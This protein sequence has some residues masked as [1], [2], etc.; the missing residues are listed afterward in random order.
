M[1]GGIQKRIEDA[2]AALDQGQIKKALYMT[3]KRGLERHHQWVEQAAR[4]CLANKGNEKAC[5]SALKGAREKLLAT[6]TAPLDD[7]SLEGLEE[8]LSPA[9]PV[10]EQKR[11]DEQLY[12][13]CEECHIAAAVTAFE[14]ICEE[15]SECNCEPV[16]RLL[17]EDNPDTEPAEWIQAMAETLE[18]AEGEAKEKATAALGGL[19][20]YLDKR[21]SPYLKELE[22]RARK[23][24]EEVEVLDK[25]EN[26]Q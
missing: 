16:Q 13:E 7:T 11:T 12:E 22:D 15:H 4:E 24:A 9:P 19:M 6:I 3:E 8:L 1:A 21:Q 10:P 18:R 14:E 26:I 17:A 20:G 23:Q 2:L 5:R 25:D